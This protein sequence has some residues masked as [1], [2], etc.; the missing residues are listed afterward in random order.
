M[1][2]K[3]CPLVRKRDI[4][5][6]DFKDEVL[7]YDLNDNRAFCLNE[8]SALVWETC[9]GDKSVTEITQIL[10]EKLSLPVNEDL[11]WFALDQLRKEKLVENAEGLSNHFAGM[12]RREVIKKVGLTSMVALPIIAS[13]VAPTS[14]HANS[15]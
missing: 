6:Q 11:V 13:L 9:D 2:P 10:S 5:V 4:V 3:N 7:I 15:A 1:K 14:V 12:S 8:T